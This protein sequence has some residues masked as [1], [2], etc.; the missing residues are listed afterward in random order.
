MDAKPY[1]RS[2]CWTTRFN[3]K[4][5]SAYKTL[6]KIKYMYFNLNKHSI[7]KQSVKALNS[8]GYGFPIQSV[9]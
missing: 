1:K 8:K 9:V 6:D 7:F 5:F 4:L 3:A 2:E